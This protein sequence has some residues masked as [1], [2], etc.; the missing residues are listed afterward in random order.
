M[1]QCAEVAR[2]AL[3]IDCTQHLG[4][5]SNEWGEQAHEQT[6]P[7][8]HHGERQD[9]ADGG[10]DGAAC[11]ACPV[12]PLNQRASNEAQRDRQDE[13]GCQVRKPE[14]GAQQ[15]GQADDAGDAAQRPEFRFER[16]E[17]QDV[18]VLRGVLH[19]GK[20]SVPSRVVALQTPRSFAN[21]APVGYFQFDVDHIGGRHADPIAC[22]M[23]D[24]I[25]DA[26]VVPHEP[27]SPGVCIGHPDEVHPCIRIS[28]VAGG[29][30]VVWRHAVP[31]VEEGLQ[32]LLC[33]NGIAH[34]EGISGP[35]G[36]SQALAVG[37]QSATLG[38]RALMI[39]LANARRFGFS[40]AEE[41]QFEHLRLYQMAN[42]IREEIEMIFS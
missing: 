1:D 11:D 23:Q 3:E 6:E 14:Q 36:K 21:A 26:G 42:K 38:Q 10:A 5:C 17:R 7:Q 33:P 41:Q 40:M 13:V 12:A 27:Q 16:A 30:D 39:T 37:F 22:Q 20:L 8:E 4:F 32:R 24:Q 2:R 9:G 34:H 15:Q 25:A 35:T 18:L 19:V 31:G 29:R 28:E